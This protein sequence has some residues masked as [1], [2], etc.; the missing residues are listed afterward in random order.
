MEMSAS[1]QVGNGTV[2]VPIDGIAMLPPRTI[3]AVVTYL[4]LLLPR[5]ATGRP[6]DGE[7]PR[8]E[9]L[10]PEDAARFDRL[11]RAIGFEWLWTSRVTWSLDEIAARL[12][13]PAF[14]CFA[15]VGEGGDVGLVEIDVSAADS[16]EIVLFGLVP[17]AVGRGLGR[18]AFGALIDRLAARPGVGRL[19][20]HTCTLDHPR[21]LGFYR[22]FGFTVFARA[23]EIGTD[24]RLSGEMA[25]EA[26]ES[27]PP[28]P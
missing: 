1:G 25:P 21:A 4:E 8:F 26:G 17:G 2:V 3:A 13:D 18:A 14:A 7:A 10:G 20:L 22:S 19:W 15:L 12:A 27:H 23:I 28:I 6:A 11:F 5:P 24:P 16:T 9:R